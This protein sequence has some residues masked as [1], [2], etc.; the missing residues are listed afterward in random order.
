MSQPLSHRGGPLSPS[1]Y[2]PPPASRPPNCGAGWSTWRCRCG[3]TVS[4]DH[5]HGGFHEAINLDGSP[6]PSRTGRERSR[7]RCLS[8]AKPGG[9]AGTGRGAR[10]AAHALDYLR[11]AFRPGRR[12]DR[13]GRR[14]RRHG[15][16][17]RAVRS[18]RPGLR[19]ARAGER[20]PRVRRSGRMAPAAMRCAAH[21]ARRHWRIRTADFRGSQSTACRNAPTRTC[22][23]SRARSPGVQSTTIR[24]GGIGAQHR[25]ALPRTNSSIPRPVRCASSS[26]PTGRPPPGIE[27]RIAEPG[28]H[29]EWAFL[30]DRWAALAGRPRPDAIGRLIAFA[31]RHGLDERRGVAVNAVR[32]DGS[33]HDPVARLWAQAE[34]IRA[35][36]DGPARP[37]R[38]APHRR[39]PRPAA[40]SC[41]LRRP[42]SGS[43]NWTRTTALSTEPARATSLYHIVGAVAEL[44]AIDGSAAAVSANAARDRASSIS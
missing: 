27:G 18:L 41:T 16:R 29:Y 25:A 42:A 19:P 6:V 36:V 3:G 28:H 7:G 30:L 2:E 22:I 35:Y 8:I 13:I 34:R 5:A 40:I 17:D 24:S 4:A 21:H 20:T 11:Q 10:R 31:D 33:L 1:P 23:S 38:R 9:S 44:A 26:P 14:S 12:T 15:I 43:T 37:R 39:D 32:T